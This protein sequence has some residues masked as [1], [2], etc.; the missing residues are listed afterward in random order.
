MILRLIVAAGILSPAFSPLGYAQQSEVTVVEQEK[1]GF[2]WKSALLQSAL[3]LS[4]QHSG[5]VIFQEKTR[6]ELGGPFFKDYWKSVRGIGGWGDGDSIFTNYYAH[7]FQGAVTGYVQIQNDPLFRRDRFSS[8]PHYWT[9]RMRA[10]SFAFAYSTFFEL[11]IASEASI[12]NVGM[13]P[14]TAGLVDFVVTPIGGIGMVVAEDAVDRYVIEKIEGRVRNQAV[15][16]TARTLLN[17]SRGFANL[18]RFRPPWHRDGRAK[19]SELD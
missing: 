10:F 13:K 19:V 16:A 5:R 15:R 12:G 8:N 17:P 3:F 6:A 9:S 11:G 1:T 4:M 2:Q 18:L 7:P 14:G